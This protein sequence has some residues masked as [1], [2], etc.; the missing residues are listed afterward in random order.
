MPSLDISCPKDGVKMQRVQIG[1]ITVDR[2]PN[3]GAMWF[4]MNELERLDRDK[5]AAN[6][7][8]V[9]PIV[10]SDVQVR[11]KNLRCPRCDEPMKERVYPDQSHVLVMECKQCQGKL[12][13]A[14]EFKDV[15]DFTVLEKIKA[16]FA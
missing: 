5:K 1:K 11:T 12:L 6:A 9:G 8:D 13:D 2:C 15:T 14:G 7:L 10:R 16:F 3:C 4:D